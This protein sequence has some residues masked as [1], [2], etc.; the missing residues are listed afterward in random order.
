LKDET[1]PSIKEDKETVPSMKEDKETVTIPTDRK[2]SHRTETTIFSPKSTVP[3]VRFHEPQLS[4]R[5]AIR[6]H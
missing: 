3:S 6:H 4:N 1:V 5:G 2:P